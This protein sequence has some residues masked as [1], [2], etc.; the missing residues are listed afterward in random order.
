M[1]AWCLHFV[2]FNLEEA[3]VRE[4]AS[5]LNSSHPMDPPR[6]HDQC[7]AKIEKMKKKLKLLNNMIGQT[8]AAASG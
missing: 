6:I 1:C 8:R 3:L 5:V 7:R 4:I 2:V